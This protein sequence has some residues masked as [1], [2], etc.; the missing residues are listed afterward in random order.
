MANEIRM[1][2]ELDQYKKPVAYH[3]LS[4]YHPGDYDF[5][6]LSASPKHI[7]IEADE[8]I[9]VFMPSEPVKRA[10]R[11]GLHQLWQL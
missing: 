9:H 1:G 8:M 4:R 7:R 6:T 2:V 3:L 10:E 11:H 5:T